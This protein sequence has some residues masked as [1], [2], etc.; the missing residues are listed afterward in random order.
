MH[1]WEHLSH[2]RELR[3]LAW[4][5]VGARA[6]PEYPPARSQL[7]SPYMDCWAKRLQPVWSSTIVVA[8]APE[9]WLPGWPRHCRI[10]FE[11]IPRILCHEA[12]AIW[13]TGGITYHPLPFQGEGS[14]RSRSVDRGAKVRPCTLYSAYF[15]RRG[16]EPGPENKEESKETPT[17][18]PKDNCGG[19]LQ[20]FHCNYSW[21]VQWMPPLSVHWV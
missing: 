6:F 19:G 5:G 3:T 10:S 20:T 1:T 4:K 21:K 2:W 17:A 7:N 16:I 9:L 11:V 14:W 15:E 12:L 8:A 18:A 13:R